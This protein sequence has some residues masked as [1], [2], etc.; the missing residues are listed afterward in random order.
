MVRALSIYTAHKLWQH[1]EHFGKF[2]EILENF[3][4]N[5]EM[6]ETFG[7][8][9]KV[10]GK[11]EELSIHRKKS[12]G[13]PGARKHCK[14]IASPERPSGSGLG[15]FSALIPHEEALKAAQDRPSIEKNE[16]KKT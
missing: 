4:K 5:W 9:L 16:E 11:L 6:L 15:H 8:L 10:L 7:T 14:T 3:W 12:T 13:R 2:L 1:L